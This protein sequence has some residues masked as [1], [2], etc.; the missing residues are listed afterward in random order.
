MN[1]IKA[2]RLKANLSQNDLAKSFGIRQSTVSMWELGESFPRADK[3]PQL[4]K[5]LG[6]KIED[7]LERKSM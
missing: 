4:A 5:M 7:L 6:C 2:L 1:N 3:L